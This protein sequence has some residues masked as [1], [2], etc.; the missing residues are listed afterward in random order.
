MVL[1]P[2]KNYQ[3]KDSL[4][5]RYIW[6][7][8]LTYLYYVKSSPCIDPWLL[9]SSVGMVYCSHLWG[10]VVFFPL[11][12]HLVYSPGISCC[13]L[14]AKYYPVL[15]WHNIWAQTRLAGGYHLLKQGDIS[16]EMST[17]P[18]ISCNFLGNRP[19]RML[20]FISQS[21][22]QVEVKVKVSPGGPHPSI[23]QA[24][25]WITS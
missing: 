25:L 19:L 4:N 9:C 16:F 1:P 7:I 8:C 20:S 21:I 2:K 14:S 11:L 24:Q 22:L 6:V 23:N 5:I 15:A 17:A 12:P 10:V 18:R 3:Q 13:S